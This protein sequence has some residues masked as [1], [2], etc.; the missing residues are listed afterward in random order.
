VLFAL[1]PGLLAGQLPAPPDNWWTNLLEDGTYP[2][3]VLEHD[4]GITTTITQSIE[5]VHGTTISIATTVSV[6]GNPSVQTNTVNATMIHPEESVAA[7]AMFSGASFSAVAEDTGAVFR[8]VEDT[9]CVVGDLELKCSLY[10]M[11][12]SGSTIRVWHA[13][14][15][16]PVFGGGFVRAE[17]TA[18]GQTMTITMTAYR[19]KLLDE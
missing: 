4:L 8:K 18:N 14:S 16:P 15:I 19:G 7:L 10:H 12:S 5:A 9:T 1:V 3:A 11:K 2:E 17:T 13:P 6:M